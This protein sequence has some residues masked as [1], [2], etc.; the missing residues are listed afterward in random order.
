MN[1]QSAFLHLWLI[2]FFPEDRGSSLL[3][4]IG[5]LLSDN[6]TSYHRAN[7]TDALTVR[8]WGVVCDGVSSPLDLAAL[9]AGSCKAVLTRLWRGP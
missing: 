9:R 5:K 3:Q 4:N 2:C 6:M 1:K 8:V 7:E